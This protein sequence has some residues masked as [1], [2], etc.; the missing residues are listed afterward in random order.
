M[1]MQMG[2][3]TAGEETPS[4]W[5]ICAV[6]PHG[7]D[8]GDAGVFTETVGQ[9][10]S[11]YQ[12]L[13]HTGTLQTPAEVEKNIPGSAEHHCQDWKH[14]VNIQRSSFSRAFNHI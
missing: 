14:V 8:I 4:M 5:E 10:Q 12:H 2:V 9:N 1:C 7:S 13:H 6:S 3:D 11:P